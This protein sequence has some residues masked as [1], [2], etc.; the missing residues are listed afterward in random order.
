LYPK[1]TLSENF[2]LGLRG[3]YFSIKKGHLEIIGLDNNGDGNVMEFT[4]SGN[5]AIGNLMLIP[6]IRLD[7]AS[8]D[9][10]L[11]KDLEPTDSMISMLLAAVYRF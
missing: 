8:E 2:A 4:L 7:K 11:K 5:Y 6:E 1:F 3:E 9:S 10:F